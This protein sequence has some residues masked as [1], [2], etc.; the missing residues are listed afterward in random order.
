[1]LL[2]DEEDKMSIGIINYGMGNIQSIK[3]ALN[4][5]SDQNVFLLNQEKDYKS[6]ETIILPGVGAFG[7]ASNRLANLGTTQLIKKHVRAGK[8]LNG[9]CLGM[10]LLFDQSEEDGSHQGLG[11]VSGTIQKLEASKVP[12]EK[13]PSMGW[14]CTHFQNSPEY[15]NVHQK[16]F[17]FVHSYHALPINPQDVLATY[18]RSDK[19]IVAA[20][21]RENVFGFQFHPERSGVLGLDLLGKV[22]T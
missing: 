13:I 20:V 7:P 4:M 11:L 3:N 19:H 1:M 9:I 22:M 5:V 15:R 10:Q 14:H 12:F 21:Q 8:K 16:K 2:K 6:V 18:K 17:Y